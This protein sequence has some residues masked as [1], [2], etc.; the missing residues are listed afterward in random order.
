MARSS[1]MTLSRMGILS[2]LALTAGRGPG[3]AIHSTQDICETGHAGGKAQQNTN[4]H[5][6]RAKAEPAAQER[7][8]KDT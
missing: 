7:G 4:K 2:F 8:S 5:D 1:R 3:K 6:P